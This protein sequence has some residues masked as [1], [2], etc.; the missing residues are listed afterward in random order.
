[1]VTPS[2][3]KSPWSSV[4]RVSRWI[5]LGE[6]LVRPVSLMRPGSKAMEA[7]GTPARRSLRSSS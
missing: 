7:T 4:V 2:L 6:V 5:N 3:L 1:M